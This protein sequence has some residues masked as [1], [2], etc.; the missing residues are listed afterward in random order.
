MISRE[1]LYLAL[2]GGLSAIAA[3][4]VAISQAIPGSESWS[5]VA[6]T[7][8]LMNSFSQG[9]FTGWSQYWYSGFQLLYTY[10]PLTY[11]LGAIL[12]WPF[13]SAL[14]GMKLLLLLSFVLSGVGAFALCRNFGISPNWSLAAGLLYSLAPPHILFLFDQGT[15]GYGLAFALCPFLFLAFRNALANP[16]P[17]SVVYLSAVGAL[18]LLSNDV[19]LYVLFLPLFAYLVVSTPKSRVLKTALVLVSSSATAFLLSAFWLIPYLNYDLSGELN[20]LG[21]APF[22][23]SEI[24]HWYSFI[25]PNFQSLTAGYLGWILILPAL[26]SIIFLRRREEFGLYAA[27]L[28]SMVLS[29][30]PTLTSFFYKIPFILSVQSPKRFLIADVLFLTPLAAL[31]FYRLFERL[32]L[33][34]SKP[35]LLK[36]AAFLLI[37]LLV[38]IPIANPSTPQV[39]LDTWH[40]SDPSQQQ[41]EGFLASQPGFFRVMVSDRFYEFFPQFTMKGSID[42]WYDQA[43]TQLY[44]NSTLVLYYCGSGTGV[45]HGLRLLGVRYVMIDFGYGGLATSELE[46]FYSSTSA[47]GPPV[48]NNSDVAIFQVPE[49]QL[50]YVSGTPPQPLSRNIASFKQD[51]ACGESIPGA[52]PNSLKSSISNLNWREDRISFDVDVNKSAFVLVSN[53]YSPGWVAEDNGSA[54]RMSLTP[55]GLPVINVTSGL[56]HIVM[57]YSISSEV[58]IGAIL[59]LV[60]L[61]GVLIYAVNVVRC[62]FLRRLS[63]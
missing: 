25:A 37:F 47:F 60:A 27:A 63:V 5:H 41:A 61:G 3:L 10:P 9:N 54:L 6:K 34:T 49:S 21:A 42:G 22:R 29:I 24:L 38:L 45:L 52:P 43:T 58:E 19:S 46:K 44:R 39:H 32:S 36:S 14:I 11:I 31:F 56:H 26:V 18:F 2:A 13:Q 53:S 1:S 20:L 35:A 51:V 50:V 57:Y 16:S 23:S 33:G 12:G 30:G 8:F 15:L 28:V 59:S 40:V 48:Y 62:L 55:P 4:P 17:S 7:A